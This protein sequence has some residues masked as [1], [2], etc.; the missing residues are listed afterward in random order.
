M[1][2]RV[3]GSGREL[4]ST[5][6][7]QL[8]DTFDFSN[9]TEV[10]SSLGLLISESLMPAWGT[11]M[12]FLHCLPFCFL[13]LCEGHMGR[14]EELQ[15]PLICRN[16]FSI[17]GI[18]FKLSFRLWFRWCT[19]WDFY[20]SI[21][22][23]NGHISIYRSSVYPLSIS[24]WIHLVAFLRTCHAGISFN[25]LFRLWFSFKLILLKLVL[26]C[27]VP[28]RHLQAGERMMTQALYKAL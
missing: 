5:Q 17:V 3:Y 21:I 27:A 26:T 20:L 4:A 2:A 16:S 7:T 25:L 28:F 10:S 14:E 11:D 13:F 18:S 12:A 23:I 6:W 9:K 8:Y 24:S 19:C 15:M 22:C 1:H